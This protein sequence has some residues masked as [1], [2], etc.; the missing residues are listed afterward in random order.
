MTPQKKQLSTD[1]YKK[2]IDVAAKK[3][4]EKKVIEDRINHDGKS[5][6]SSQ[7]DKP[8]D[9]G[10][11]TQSTK[12]SS[13]D[14]P[15]T[16]SHKTLVADILP[17]GKLFKEEHFVDLVPFPTEFKSE[18]EALMSYNDFGIWHKVQ[19]KILSR[20]RTESGILSGFNICCVRRGQSRS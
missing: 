9:Q 8:D 17:G 14:E 5:E 11:G 7:E 4:I 1:N 2:E 15:T 19:F 6:S 10:T 3:E 16:H 13:S 12:A 18:E 20:T